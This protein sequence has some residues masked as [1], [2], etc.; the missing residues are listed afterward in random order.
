MSVDKTPFATAAELLEQLTKIVEQNPNALV[1]AS[2]GRGYLVLDNL[3]DELDSDGDSRFGVRDYG[4]AE[5]VSVVE[6]E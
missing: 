5:L 6:T 4:T 3:S 2:S 1:M